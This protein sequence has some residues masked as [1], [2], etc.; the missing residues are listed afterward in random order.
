LNQFQRTKIRFK[1]GQGFDAANSIL[2]FL[3]ENKQIKKA[4][5]WFVYIDK[6][7]KEIKWQ[8]ADNTEEMLKTNPTI[9]EEWKEKIRLLYEPA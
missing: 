9:D 1:F 3:L 7:K 2:N 6:N 4:G 5:A 8:G